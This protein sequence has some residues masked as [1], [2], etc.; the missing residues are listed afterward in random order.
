MKEELIAFC[1]RE[2]LQISGSKEELYTI[3]NHYLNTKEKTQIKRKKSVDCAMPSLDTLIVENM[4][5]SEVNRAFF[6][7]YLGENFRFSVAFQRWLKTNV[8]KT[9]QDAIEVYPTLSRN[10]EI[11]KQFEYNTYIRD[12]FADNKNKSLK[13]AIT[14]WKYKKSIAGYNQYEKKDL[15]ALLR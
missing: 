1:K 10:K 3:I 14:C 6:R 13:D 8:G 7:R 5:F 9:F 11:D 12:F 15:S 2:G 4:R